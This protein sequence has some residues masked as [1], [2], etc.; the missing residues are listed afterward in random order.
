MGLWNAEVKTGIDTGFQIAGIAISHDN[1]RLSVGKPVFRDIMIALH[2]RE[3]IPVD[4]EGFL[5]GDI[6]PFEEESISTDKGRIVSVTYD[7]KSA[8]SGFGE[9]EDELVPQQEQIS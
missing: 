5:A 9:V 2:P 4:E 1:D 3:N 8:G 7:G 6:R